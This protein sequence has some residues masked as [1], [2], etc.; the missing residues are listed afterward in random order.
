MAGEEDVLLASKKAIESL[1][2]CPRGEGAADAGHCAANRLLVAGRGQ[3]E[4]LAQVTSV[5]AAVARP[6]WGRRAHC[7]GT[8]GL[9]VTRDWHAASGSR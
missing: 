8:P 6:A 1:K 3:V 4:R 2:L 5:V 9:A 7:T